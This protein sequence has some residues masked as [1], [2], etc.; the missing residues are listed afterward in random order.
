MIKY[1]KS[2]NH[3]LSL[4]PNLQTLASYNPIYQL[5]E[6]NNINSKSYEDIILNPFTYKNIKNFNVIAH[7]TRHWLD[8]ISTLWGQ[9]YMIN[10]YN[11]IESKLSLDENQFWRMSSLAS[12]IKRNKFNRYFNEINK[13][14][15]P[16]GET[17]SW[18][19]SAGKR[20]NFE[21]FSDDK[22]PIIF[23]RFT[24]KS[25]QYVCRVPFTIGSLLETNA[26]AEEFNAHKS[27]I[28]TLPKEEQLIEYNLLKDE[29]IK[30]LYDPEMAIYSIAAHFTSNSLYNTDII[31]AFMKSSE[32][33]TIC[34]NFPDRLFKELRIPNGFEPWKHINDNFIKDR[35][36]GY[37]FACI[38]A[39][40]REKGVTSSTFDIDT[41]LRVSNLPS[42]E[43]FQKITMEE[44]EELRKGITSGILNSRLNQLLDEG[45]RLFKMRGVKGSNYLASHQV[46]KGDFLP[47]ILFQDTDCDLY[48]YDI[49]NIQLNGTSDWLSF[50][51]EVEYKIEEFIDICGL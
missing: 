36:I 5:I 48:D 51:N 47:L 12:E 26:M 17:W 3:K 31:S 19:L 39:N 38:L 37:I 22:H 24:S 16:D 15:L 23:T 33:S 14:Y 42:T 34:L 11:A 7:E 6:L 35:N 10:I 32:M 41:A 25:G 50:I 49:T 27:F 30:W 13:A 40:C 44:I 46:I 1:K 45:T 18:Q 9:K 2:K 29:T 21:G 43:E 8:H 20:F 28:E 4:F